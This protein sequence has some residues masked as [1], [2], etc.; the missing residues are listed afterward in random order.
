MKPSPKAMKPSTTIAKPSMFGDV[1][2][3]T[4]EKAGDEGHN[5]SMKL[6]VM[7]M[8]QPSLPQGF[9]DEAYAPHHAAYLQEERF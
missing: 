6:G 4:N 3:A 2:D 9:I 8:H 1:D 5:N 7:V